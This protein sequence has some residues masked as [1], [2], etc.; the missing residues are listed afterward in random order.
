MGSGIGG[1]Q[2]LPTGGHMKRCQGPTLSVAVRRNP[3]TSQVAPNRSRASLQ[4]CTLPP[5]SERT[6]CVFGRL[7]AIPSDQSELGCEKL[8]QY[9][10]WICGA[11]G[12]TE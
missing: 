9:R 1:H 4:G 12:R 3:K 7:L 8:T 10:F 11:Y 2:K 5:G 6:F